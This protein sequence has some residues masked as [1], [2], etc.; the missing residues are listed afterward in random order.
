M[1]GKEQAPFHFKIH[2]FQS[3]T[4]PSGQDGYAFDSR[5]EKNK[6][7]AFLQ[8]FGAEELQVQPIPERGNKAN[9]LRFLF[10]IAEQEKAQQLYDMIAVHKQKFL[11][12]TDQAMQIYFLLSEKEFETYADVSAQDYYAEQEKRQ[13]EAEERKQAER[14]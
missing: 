2:L 14:E 3:E 11:P 1:I 5:T 13:Q 9:K 12:E 4:R 6:M 8:D 10:Q 7:M